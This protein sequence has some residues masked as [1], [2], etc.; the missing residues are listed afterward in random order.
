[1]SSSVMSLNN[2]AWGVPMVGLLGKSV[3]KTTQTHSHEMRSLLCLLVCVAIASCSS[4][5]ESGLT[6]AISDLLRSEYALRF[7]GLQVQPVSPLN[8]TAM[9]QYLQDQ[10]TS[11]TDVLDTQV[12]VIAKLLV[13]NKQKYAQI[14][15]MQHWENDIEQQKYVIRNLTAIA[16]AAS[17]MSSARLVKIQQ[18]GA[19]LNN[20]HQEIDALRQHVGCIGRDGVK[21]YGQNQYISV[22][23]TDNLL[24]QHIRIK[25]RPVCHFDT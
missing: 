1:M 6:A 21:Y 23:Q 24:N 16:A 13:L 19:Q 22:S 15:E 4:D 10:V 17:S 18:L 12:E 2:V 8:H 11:M 3:L 9:N 5:L 25:P 7:T 14:K 20:A